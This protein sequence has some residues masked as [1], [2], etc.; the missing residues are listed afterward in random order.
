MWG[1][2]VAAAEGWS[3]LGM[4]I[5]MFSA[6]L[7]GTAIGVDRGLKR[8]GAGIKTHAL[9]CLGAALV[10]MTGEYIN[11]RF[12]GNMDISRLGA[13]V[14]SGVGFL[15]VGT[16]IVTGRNQVRGLTT[17]AGL[18]ACACLGLAVGIGF[19][20]GALI[21]LVMVMFTL[22]ILTR[23]DTWM[24]TYAKV[25]DLYLEFPTNK[26]VSTFVDALHAE[27]IK[28]CS[29]ELGKSK[30]KGEGPN[31]ILCIEVKD[32][33]KRCTILNTIQQMD[34]VRFAEEL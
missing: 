8:R 21:T 7:I 10:M 22:K 17:A 33:K 2:F 20:E 4:T 24:H 26:S 16:I 3:P 12:A 29:F 34:C 23:A 5:R 13:Q 6:L 14:V 31:A 1:H 30:I 11:R 15:G 28:I 27:G 18:W 19:V 25:F 9:V 32:R